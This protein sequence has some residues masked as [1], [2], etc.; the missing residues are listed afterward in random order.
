M[1]NVKKNN[2][3]AVDSTATEIIDLDF[4]VSDEEITKA[5]QIWNDSIKNDYLQIKTSTYPVYI[6]IYLLYLYIILYFINIHLVYQ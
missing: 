5:A 6:F 3:S 1:S 4:N 2:A